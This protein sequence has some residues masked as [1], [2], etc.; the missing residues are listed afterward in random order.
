ME[1]KITEVSKVRPTMAVCRNCSSTLIIDYMGDG[2]WVHK[3]TG[4][5]HCR[6][7]YASAH[8]AD[9]MIGIVTVTKEVVA[10]E[11]DPSYCMACGNQLQVGVYPGGTFLMGCSCD[12]P[13]MTIVP[14]GIAFVWEEHEDVVPRDVL[15]KI[16][17]QHIMI[18]NL[19]KRP[20]PRVN[21]TRW[22]CYCCGND[23][24]HELSTLKIPLGIVHVWS[25]QRIGVSC[26]VTV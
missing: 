6:G 3:S 21:Y 8:N 12:K 1:P 23:K 17:F 4:S 20:Q 9:P 10:H 11:D 16:K 25:E 19:C 13:P 18:C 22:R 15:D 5:D 2:A 26:H 14:R 24:S 7:F